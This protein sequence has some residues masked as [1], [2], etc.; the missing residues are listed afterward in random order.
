MAAHPELL[1]PLIT[2]SD[3][4]RVQWRNLFILDVEPPGVTWELML[5][6]HIEAIPR[7]YELTLKDQIVFEK[8]QTRKLAAL[9]FN[10]R[11]EGEDQRILDFCR[12][13]LESDS[14]NI[15][16]VRSALHDAIGYGF[17]VIELLWGRRDGMWVIERAIERPPTLF[18]FNRIGF[19]QTGELGILRPGSIAP[20]PVP[21][22]KFVVYSFQPDEGDRTGTPLLREVFW[23]CWISR[24]AIKLM[25]KTAEKGNGTVAV[26]YSLPGSTVVTD[27]YGRQTTIAAQAQ[28]LAE[29]IA[30]STAVSHG[31]VFSVQLLERARQ[32]DPTVFRDII[33]WAEQRIS[34]VF[35]G[36]TLTSRGGDQGSGSYALGR[37]HFEIF[38]Q[39]VISDCR[40]EELVI[41]QQILSP[42]VKLNFGESAPVPRYVVEIPLPEPELAP[43]HVTEGLVTINEARRRLGLPPIPGGDSFLRASNLKDFDEEWWNVK[44]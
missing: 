18:A 34:L 26:S 7:Y 37:V 43:W 5:T 40:D 9:S 25:L 22:F 11:L 3:L 13:V 12:S 33:Q 28:A 20:E 32:G 23:P 29:A 6:N 16:A 27:E 36:E 1:R 30:N 10:W 4:W 42:L 35:T 17:T 15:R 8:F 39:K 14:F 38:L 24:Q 41:S 44:P 31:D 21:P 2:D 19:P